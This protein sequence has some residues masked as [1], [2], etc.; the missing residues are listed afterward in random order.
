MIKTYTR[1]EKLAGLFLFLT[2]IVGVSL[3]LLIGLGKGWFQ[4]QQTYQVKF[5]Q[6]YNLQPGSAVKMF[7]TEIGK[8]T[9][10]RISRLRDEN[11]VVIT[12]RVD[13]EYSDLIRLDSIAEVES[14]TIL[15]SE[16]LSISP[17]TYGYPPIEA[18]GTIPSRVQKTLADYLEEFQPEESLRKAKQFVSNMAFL[19]EQLK[20][21]EQKLLTTLNNFD[22]VLVSILEAKGTL[23]QLLMQKDFYGRLELAL[24][25]VEAILKNSEELTKNLK[26][27]SENVPGLVH[28]VGQQLDQVKNLLTELQD[29]ARKLPGLLETTDEAARTGKEVLDAVK[30]NPIVKM[31]LPETPPSQPIHVE[32]R[33]AP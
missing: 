31:T 6:S 2:L 20:S 18:Y 10:L 13:A 23:G 14:P 15:G 9:R 25:R 7:N 30:A 21:H 12:I 1:S 4:R 8:V 33:H 11:Q 19:S 24:S 5:P 16:F 28:N 29:A 17:G 26:A 32:P 22:A 3:V 27:A